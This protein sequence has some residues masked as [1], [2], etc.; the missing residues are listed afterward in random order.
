MAAK[1]IREKGFRKERYSFAKIFFA[2]AIFFLSTT[3]DG[4]FFRQNKM[5]RFNI[6]MYVLKVYILDNF[7]TTLRTLFST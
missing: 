5:P 7:T 4:G 6:F 2:V 3:S 1:R